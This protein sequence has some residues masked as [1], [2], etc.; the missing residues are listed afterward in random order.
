M[1][2][3][4]TTEETTRVHPVDK[5][6]PPGRLALYGVQHVMASYAGMLIVPLIL[7]SSIGLTQQELV[8]LISAN[9]FACGVA[10][11]IQSVGFW[12][13]GVRLP[14]VLGT[15]FTAVA[16]MIAIGN[17]AGG[18]VDGLLVIYGAVLVAGI[19][20][21]LVAPYYSRLIRFFPPVVTGTVITV[22]GLSLLPVAILSAGGGDPSAQDFGGL[23]NLALAAVPL[24][25]ILALYRFFPGFLS[26]I[27]VLLGL[28][29][30][31][32]VATAFGIVD[33]GG[34]SDAGWVNLVTPLEFGW[35]VF[36][37]AAIVCMTI[38]MLITMVETTGDTFAVGNIV[39]KPIHREDIAR[40]IRADG[41]ATWISGLFNSFPVTTFSGNIGL[42]RLSRIRSRWVVASAG[43][44]MI[45]VSLF[46]KVA[47]VFTSIPDPVVGAA[48]LILFG[49]IAVVGIQT[50]TRVDF[51]DERNVII[52]AV[53]IGLGVIPVAFPEFFVNLP[54]SAQV[55]LGSG[56]TLATVSALT[57]NFL[58][59]V[60][61]GEKNLAEEGGSGP[62]M[63]EKFSMDQ[64]N[65][66]SPEEFVQ[67]FNQVFQGQDWI[68]EEAA[69]ERPFDSLYDLRRA[70]QDAIFDGP[71]EHQTEL[72]GSYPD[73][74][75]R[76]LSQELS[77][78]DGERS[79]PSG[80]MRFAPLGGMLSLESLR[81]QSSAGLDRLSTEEQEAFDRL[82]QAYREKFGFPLIVCARENTKESILANGNARLENP[83]AQ[84][85]ATAL[86]ELAKIANYRLEDLVEEPSAEVTV[87][88]EA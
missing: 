33:F 29:V 79:A 50:L 66:L 12:K 27:A 57:L 39:E 43:A 88:N 15:T 83:P 11:V 72:L 86:V 31:T 44:I 36:R 77:R 80:R 28:V 82:N 54:E 3:A 71:P 7:A 6:L 47:A 64:V 9:L 13:V 81:D 1:A 19:L 45:V 46:P 69:N 18:G 25:L 42:V 32:A 85:R 16:P 56:I 17:A 62:R 26:T 68:P 49:T 87:G 48:T 52:V 51:H 59:N 60:L 10:T 70:F 63:P 38:V 65:R 24:V 5:V 23:Q 41:L 21:L 84:E 22:I 53:S 58:F 76:T 37:L 67:S 74:G 34:V 30:G 35:P 14:V 55:V 78:S 2:Q 61:G 75:S 40:A 8:F 20:T 73:L 4:T